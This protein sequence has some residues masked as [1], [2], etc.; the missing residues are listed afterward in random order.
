[1]PHPITEARTR[2]PLSSPPMPHLQRGGYGTGDCRA[3]A[4]RR[5]ATAAESCTNR[6]SAM[7]LGS[8]DAGSTRDLSATRCGNGLLYYSGVGL[9]SS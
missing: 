8:H 9:D 6:F 7:L 1:M 5:T 3:A 2:P 4:R